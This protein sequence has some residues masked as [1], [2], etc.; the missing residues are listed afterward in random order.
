MKE[1][2]QEGAEGVEFG[3]RFLRSKPG[4][5]AEKKASSS[6]LPMAP[7]STDN[8]QRRKIFNSQNLFYFLPW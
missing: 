5:E 3:D 6:E 1:S 8:G 4:Y 7:F 2:P